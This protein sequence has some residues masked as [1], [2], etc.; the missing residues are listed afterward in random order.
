ME[1]AIFAHSTNGRFAEFTID[2]NDHAGLMRQKPVWTPPLPDDIVYVVNMDHPAYSHLAKCLTSAYQ[3]SRPT[4]FFTVSL[5]DA[6]LHF[7]VE[8]WLKDGQGHVPNSLLDLLADE[9]LRRRALYWAVTNVALMLLDGCQAA[10]GFL[11]NPG[12]DG[13]CPEVG[14]LLSTL[15]DVREQLNTHQHQH[16][17]LSRS[18]GGLCQVVLEGIRAMKGKC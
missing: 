10:I 6:N 14:L 11:N 13:S 3:R 15:D 5:L 7:C 4:T 8:D 12:H 17:K 9:Q 16:Q 2:W 1:I 18:D